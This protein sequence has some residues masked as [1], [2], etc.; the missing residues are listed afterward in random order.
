[1]GERI[2]SGSSRGGG[3]ER[4][5]RSDAEDVKSLQY[6]RLQE[7]ATRSL[8]SGRWGEKALP[9]AHMSINSKEDCSSGKSVFY[10]CR[11]YFLMYNNRK[12]SSNNGGG[13]VGEAREKQDADGSPSRTR[14]ERAKSLEQDHPG[15]PPQSTSLPSPCS[16]RRSP[17]APA[18]GGRN[19]V[20]GTGNGGREG[21][22]N[23]S[24]SHKADVHQLLSLSDVE[25]AFMNFTMSSTP[26]Q[27]LLQLRVLE[28]FQEWVTSPG[29]WE[30]L[31]VVLQVA[32]RRAG[33]K[34]RIREAWKLEPS[35]TCPPINGGSSV[36]SSEDVGRMGSP[37]RRQGG[38]LEDASKEGRSGGE[39]S[40]KSKT[41]GKDD[42]N[43]LLEER[44]LS[45]NPGKEISRSRTRS[46][47]G[48]TDPPPLVKLGIL[49]EEENTPNS[50]RLSV[51]VTIETPDANEKKE[52][53]CAEERR[54]GSAMRR[55]RLAASS[56]ARIKRYSASYEDIPRFYFPLGEPTTTEVHI[57]SPLF[58]HH[59]NPHLRLTESVIA[60]LSR[61]ES[62]GIGPSEARGGGET[63]VKTND[64]FSISA[65]MPHSAKGEPGSGTGRNSNS[66]KKVGESPLSERLL[67]KLPPMS[68]LH[69]TEDR[70]VGEQIKKEFSRLNSLG[71]H[72]KARLS[73]S[74]RVA[75]SSVKESQLRQHFYACMERICTDCLGIPKYFSYLLVGL[76]QLQLIE[77]GS[78][79]QLTGRVKGGVPFISPEGYSAIK[80]EH[81]YNFYEDYLQ[82]KNS[83]RRTFD[84]LIM[85]SRLS[86]SLDDKVE[87][88][89]GEEER[90][91]PTSGRE[92]GAENEKNR[93]KKS[94][95]EEWLSLR[96]YLVPD[97]FRAFLVTLLYCHPGLSFLTQTPEFQGKYVDTVI[98]RIFYT[99]DR[100]DRGR[101][102]FGEFKPS[103]LFDAFREVDAT[104]DINTVLLYFSY[105]HFYVLYCRFWELDDDR[106]FLI[107]REDLMEYS[108][109]G[110]MNPLV[111]E[112][113]FKGAGRPIK[114]KV[115]DRI[116]YEDFVW[117]CLSEED[118]S[119]TTAIRYWFKLLDTDEDGLLSLYEI[120]NFFD[121]TTARGADYYNDSVVSFDHIICQVFDMLRCNEFRP[122]RLED[123]LADHLA[124]YVAINMITNIAKF[125]QFE[126]KDPFV[127]YQERLSGPVEQTPWDR[128]ARQEY[129]RMAL[130]GEE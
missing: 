9:D 106:D 96:D 102:S 72:Q 43:L 22:Y 85:S 38:G 77:T 70:C 14:R 115:P 1:M 82:N 52:V 128:F 33:L 21:Y 28:L 61:E 20:G 92:R 71:R 127:S 126:F 129:D 32:Q 124:T 99:L 120:R 103:S 86:A 35:F 25:A 88:Q 50:R 118:K 67:P 97:D 57:S 2:N 15:S 110:S 6:R 122:L 90:D 54:E 68:T 105:E 112:R 23:S 114:C 44:S 29:V 51:R 3:G 56:S 81:V 94:L 40:N 69:F 74:R 34:P 93:E 27:Q 5:S 12:A 116:G 10:K 121:S 7:S 30:V 26:S 130:E 60:V 42:T 59:E 8:E 95:K 89:E 45:G 39:K 73:S 17:C 49:H 75:A 76:I 113:V 123:L 100:F 63:G 80:E 104:D 53:R 64:G 55:S 79:P 65:E 58:K 78:Y 36:A 119:T 13:G 41:N 66:E 31:D 125:I 109:I 18:N 98:Y 91:K 101:I 11:E 48:I 108:P 84:L 111:V 46:S 47:S 24:I 62:G 19:C 16:G 107:S 87:E 4:N 117:F 83:Y 37:D